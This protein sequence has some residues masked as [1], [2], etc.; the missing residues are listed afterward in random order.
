MCPVIALLSVY[1]T[2]TMR[3]T[4]FSTVVILLFVYFFY[5]AISFLRF[6]IHARRAGFPVYLSPVLS[7][8]IPW[9]VL[10]PRQPSSLSSRNICRDGSMSD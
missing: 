5:K 4:I 7:K 2:A 8:S 9:L 3:F 10:A 6:Y 1:H